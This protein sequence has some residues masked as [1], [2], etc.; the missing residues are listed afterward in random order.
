MSVTVFIGIAAIFFII[1]ILC[2][3]K[4][5]SSEEND[6]VPISNPKEIEEL[7]S[8]FMPTEKQEAPGPQTGASPKIGLSNLSKEP[9]DAMSGD[10]NQQSEI[11]E[12]IQKNEQLEQNLQAL[13]KEKEQLLPNHE[14]INDLK[15]KGDLFEKQ[16]ADNKI[17]Q[18]ELR[19]FIRT[20]KSEKEELLKSQES[21]VDKT[22]FN[23]IGGRLNE[24]LAAIAALKGENKDLQ[25]FNQGL[26]D[27][28]KKTREHNEHLIEKEKL[29]EY[30][31]SKN[32]A[33]AVGLEKICEGFKLKIENLTAIASG[34]QD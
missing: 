7:K 30:E 33:Q 25:Q 24:S 21:G 31:L 27:D 23:A 12:L 20:L 32:R 29:M 13:N 26:K 14:L 34:K 10:S 16:H 5:T 3:I 2:I 17:Q 22:E 6:A 9:G 18:E 11:T 28:F 1:G 4:G 8:S 15:A 19:E